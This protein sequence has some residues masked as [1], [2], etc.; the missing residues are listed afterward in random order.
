MRIREAPT[1]A[2][3]SAAYHLFVAEEHEHAQPYSGVTANA[4]MPGPLRAF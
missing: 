4:L 1:E 2:Q 3:L